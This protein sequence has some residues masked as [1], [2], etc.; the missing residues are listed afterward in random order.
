MK[1]YKLIGGSGLSMT[2][3][4]EVANGLNMNGLHAF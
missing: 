3:I 4:Y 1:L 2:A